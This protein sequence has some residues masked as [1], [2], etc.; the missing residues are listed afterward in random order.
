MQ[1]RGFR[2]FNALHLDLRRGPLC[3]LPHALR[4][5]LMLLFSG[6]SVRLSILLLKIAHLEL[7]IPSAS[8]G[9]QSSEMASVIRGW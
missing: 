3:I 7:H 5:R 2:P 4:L 9:W 8:I 1:D 6:T